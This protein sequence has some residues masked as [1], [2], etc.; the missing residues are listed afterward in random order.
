MGRDMTR[1][2]STTGDRAPRQMSSRRGGEHA[3]ASSVDPSEAETEVTQ[4]TAMRV[5]RTQKTSTDIQYEIKVEKEVTV[6]RSGRRMHPLG[7]H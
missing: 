5:R 6:T 7:S 3:V 2:S 1:S 4:T